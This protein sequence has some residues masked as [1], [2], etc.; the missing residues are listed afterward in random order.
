MKAV[1]PLIIALLMLPTAATAQGCTALLTSDNPADFAAASALANKLGADI[2]STP[3]GTLS[4]ESVEQVIASKCT[5]ALVVGG[6]VAVPDAE[7]VLP[8]YNIAV[9]RIGGADRYETSA[10]TAERWETSLI[11]IVAS[12]QDR[13]GISEAS[14][15]ANS[16]GAPVVFVKSSGVPEPVADAIGKLKAEEATLIP[17][18]DMDTA[19]IDATIRERGITKVEITEIDTAKRTKTAIDEASAAI[20][21]AEAGIGEIS[22]A[23][24]IAAFRLIENAREHLNFATHAQSGDGFSEA[25]SHATA[26][27]E[28]AENSKMISSGTVVGNLKSAVDEAAREITGLVKKRIDIAEISGNPI[29]YSGRE[30]QVIG[31]VLSDPVYIGEKTYIEMQDATGTIVIEK[32]GFLGPPVVETGDT[33]KVTGVVRLNPDYGGP[34]GQHSNLPAYIIEA[35]R[36]EQVS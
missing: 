9:E 3:W 32:E 23:S 25:F 34:R 1:L 26:A 24:S 35:T 6:S 12:G 28:N 31:T 18:P 19:S 22:D 7:N 5:K 13:D 16:V 14:R 33:I 27:R 11:V 10:L 36:I 20:L 4:D 8:Q 2:V 29:G 30:V 21:D 17:A 15:K